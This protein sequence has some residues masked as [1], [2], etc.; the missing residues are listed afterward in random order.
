MPEI[1]PFV[2]VGYVLT[3]GWF[4]RMHPGPTAVLASYFVGWAVL[5]VTIF[6]EQ[7]IAD[8]VDFPVMGLALP[9]NGLISKAVVISAC[10]FIS[11][12]AFDFKTLSRFRPRLFDGVAILFALT[13][14][15]SAF[16]NEGAMVDGLLDAIYLD[17]AWVGPY[18]LGRVYLNG[19]K[20]HRQLLEAITLAALFALPFAIVEFIAGPTFY[21]MLFGPH[22]YAQTGAER[23]VLHR[24]M[25]MMEDGNQ[26]GMWIAG[27]A[28]AC[29]ALWRAGRE[30]IGPVPTF[31]ALV[32]LGPTLLL[33]QSIGAI[34][35][36]VMAVIWIVIVD[37]VDARWLIIPLI[38]L[39]VAYGGLRAT[40]KLHA[41]RF[42]ADSP[43]GPQVKQVFKDVGKG[44][45][46]W[47]LKHEETH[48]P[49]AL[50]QPVLGH[51]STDWWRGEPAGRPWSLWSLTLGA[52]GVVG[53]GLMAALLMGPPT[54]WQLRLTRFN[55]AMPY[56]RCGVGVCAIL[57]IA[58]LDALLNSA[59]LLPWLLGAGALVGHR[60]GKEQATQSA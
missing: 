23:Y 34:G 36:T 51:G 5:P 25:L 52:Y 18:V 53:M 22:P 17:L 42:V 49:I 32:I 60:P 46:G 28:V 43:I 27:G 35:L 8:L 45:L 44:S 48:L 54:L 14:I 4:F 1:V 29:F 3:C 59:L 15:A 39:L 10:T 30:Q 21:E 13:P 19:Y 58:A 50:D 41:E 20:G 57:I 26:M 7:A 16:L 6:D 38:A 12:L 9:G 11:A 56:S 47:R 33:S 2:L 24:P 55:R 40:G 37:H 31:V